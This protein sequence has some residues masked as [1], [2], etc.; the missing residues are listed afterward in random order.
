MPGQSRAFDPDRVIAHTGQH[1]QPVEFIFQR[2][3]GMRILAGAE[4]EPPVSLRLLGALRS[5]SHLFLR[6]GV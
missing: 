4:L 3:I 2:R 5:D 1:S 6:Y